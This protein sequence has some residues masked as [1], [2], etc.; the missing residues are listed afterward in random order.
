MQ[1]SGAV[2]TVE[3]HVT[4]DGYAVAVAGLRVVIPNRQ[5]LSAA[6]VPERHGVL[7]PLESAVELR[8]LAVTKQERQQGIALSD[9][10]L[11]DARGEALIH[12]QRLPPGDR[13]GAYYGMLGGGMAVV[14]QIGRAVAP[15]VVL[16][17]VMDC[18]QSG[19]QSLQPVRQT[20]V[21]RVHVGEQRVT[22]R[23]RHLHDAQDAAQWRF[24]VARHVGVPQAAGDELHLVVAVDYQ[25]LGMLVVF[26]G[27][28]MDVQLAEAAAQCLVLR[29]REALIAEEQDQMLRPGILQLGQDGSVERLRQ[30]YAGHFGADYGRQRRDAQGGSRHERRRT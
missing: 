8:A 1:A 17:A 23:R 13:M 3:R 19:Q 15:P 16:F 6:V 2:G 9:R 4:L 26:R 11:L 20:F 29:E 14:A 21:G 5:V 28:R 25:D 27:G 24:A 7:A 22:A 30:V 10:Q 18:G 12:E